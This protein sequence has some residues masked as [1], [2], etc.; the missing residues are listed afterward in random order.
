MN[1][2]FRQSMSWLHTW[3]GLTFGWVLYFM[4]ITGTAGYFDSEIDHWMKPELPLAG[5]PLPQRELLAM[6]EIYLNQ[7]SANANDWYIDLPV[8][9]EDYLSLS[10]EI[11]KDSEEELEEGEADHIDGDA[12]LD[13]QTGAVITAQARDSGGGQLLY[14]MHYV[15][16]YMP[17][18]VA[19]WFVSLCSMFM[20][21]GL[22]TGVVVH[23]K[24][25][26]EFFTFRPNKKQRSWLDMHNLFSVLS[27]PFL[28]MIT[29]SG[30]MYLMFTSMP[31]GIVASYGAGEENEELFFDEAYQSFE[32]KELSN[33]PATMASLSL[34]LADVEKRWGPEQVDYI[35]AEF[36]GDSSA[37]VEFGSKPGSNRLVE[38]PTLTYDGVS[39]ELL[40][41]SDI[42]DSG[43]EKFDAVMLILHEGLFADTLLRCLYF[44][45]GLLGAGMVGTGLILWT[46]KRKTTAEK[47]DIPH[48]GLA[49][50]ERLN[51]GTIVGLPIA[52]A[53]YFWANRLIPV[54]F[55]GRAE[56]EVH[57]LFITL[58]LTLIYPVFRSVQ[59]TWIELL[60]F[61]A[62]LYTLLP[63]LN[64]LTTDRHLG[65]SIPQGDWVMAGFDLT[66]LV[67]GILFSIAALKM[68]KKE[69][70]T[71]QS[72]RINNKKQES[73]S[74]TIE[75][76]SP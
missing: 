54:S 14:Q 23:K 61:G 59:R 51:V 76:V 8:E 6:A 50:V 18:N 67:F 3:A 16:H 58:G 45:A 5:E 19:A 31:L 41:I 34:M 75:S 64:F 70:L 62:L 25:F 43:P 36:I 40:Y 20:L 49:L 65:I 33:G 2:F 47:S 38:S 11:P 37:H 10:W 55:E 12:N 7:E 66:M 35:S 72:T 56:W 4:F 15:L 57:A 1:G 71:K 30:L 48:K 42:N 21:V 73:N 17:T 68:Y 60:G 44:F 53:I 39:G 9:R 13:P 63:I 28:L 24:I 32:H 74:M 46:V 27:L 22:I 52:V 26:K 29:Y 69:A